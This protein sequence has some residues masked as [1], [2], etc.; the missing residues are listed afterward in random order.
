M[1][2]PSERYRAT[3]ADIDAANA[4]DP[5]R[6][7]IDGTMRPYEVVYSERMTER[8]SA[9]YSDASELLRIAARGQHVRRFD[10]PRTRFP[11]GRE[12]YNEWRRSCREHH[13]KLLG[14]IMRRHGYDEGDIDHVVK[15]VKKEQLK[16][17]KESQSLE[18][19]VDVIFLEHYF[20]E[21]RGKHPHYD[22]AK[23]IDIIG[24]TLRKMSPKGHQAALALELPERT[25][26]LILAAVEREAPALAKLAEVAID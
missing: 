14:E 19:V 6:I 4:D 1:F 11:N 24:K 16:K 22:D 12:G 8:L 3:I 7:V 18:N 26:K 15:L 5:R 20:D 25:R 9:M 2:Q 10:I 21:F 23:I 13:G 17:D